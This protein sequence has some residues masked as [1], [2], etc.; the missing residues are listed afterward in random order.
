MTS[1]LLRVMEHNGRMQCLERSTIFH[2]PDSAPFK[3]R[4]PT[5]NLQKEELIHSYPWIEQKQ[6]P[7]GILGSRES[8]PLAG[9]PVVRPAV[10]SEVL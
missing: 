5:S 8:L 10:F 1:T 4:L 3:Q 7:T 2:L 6:V 9:E